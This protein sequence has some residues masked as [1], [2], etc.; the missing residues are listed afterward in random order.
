M[1]VC[2]LERP[3]VPV[4]RVH[5]KQCHPRTRAVEH[6]ID[7]TTLDETRSARHAENLKEDRPNVKKKTPVSF[8]PPESNRRRPACQQNGVNVE[9]SNNANEGNAFETPEIEPGSVKRFVDQRI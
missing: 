6:M 9:K 7:K 5:L 3:S 4:G 2:S 1:A 8:S